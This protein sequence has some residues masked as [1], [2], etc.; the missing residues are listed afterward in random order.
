M[1]AKLRTAFDSESFVAKLVVAVPA[2]ACVAVYFADRSAFRPSGDGFCS[3]IFARSLAFDGDVHSANPRRDRCGAGVV[4]RVDLRDHD[5]HRSGVRRGHGVALVQRRA[6][7][8]AAEDRR[9]HGAALRVRLAAVPVLDDGGALLARVPRAGGRRVRRRVA[10]RDARAAPRPLDAEGDA[11]RR[12]AE[13]ERAG[14]PRR[15]PCGRRRR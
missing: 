8:R 1:I 3:W 14:E 12:V 7:P 4:R 9:L 2:I 10:V 13:A 11:H 5:P 6:L 15:G